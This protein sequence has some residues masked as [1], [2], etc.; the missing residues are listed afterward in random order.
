MRK[1]NLFIMGF[2]II[3]LFVTYIGIMNKTP[4][5]CPPELT[6]NRAIAGSLE[7]EKLK[8]QVK[9]KHLFIVIDSKTK[10][11]KLYGD[12]E[13]IKEYH[14]AL[15][16]SKTPTPI[17]EWTII[18]KGVNWGGGFGSR[19][20]GFNV[21]WGKYGIHGTNEPSSIGAYSSAGCVRMH[22]RSV[23]EL[24]PIIPKGTKVFIIGEYSP[25]KMRPSLKKGSS[26]H[27]VQYLQV[28][29]RHNGYDGGYLDGYF[30]DDTKRA[31]MEFQRNHHLE[32]T[33]ELDGNTMFLLSL[34]GI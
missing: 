12:N 5:G 28:I 32:V 1:M 34:E 20:L 16:R 29:L 13:V 25:I 2:L 3:L 23:E 27:D 7:A 22:N 30:G 4:C 19:W 33:G 24:Y 9:G 31:I 6:E 8:D 17:G 26:G 18:S 10:I 11:L 15:G 21:P 14:V